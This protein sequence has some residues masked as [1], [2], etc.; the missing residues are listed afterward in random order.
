MNFS[1]NQ[2]TQFFLLD[3]AAPTGVSTDGGLKY[4]VTHADGSVEVT[5]V[6]KNVSYAKVLSAS[7]AAIKL[8]AGRIVL[9]SDVADGAPVTGQTYSICIN[10]AG[11]IGGEDSYHKFASV[12]A[13]SAMHDDA[14]KFYKAL[15][16]DLLRQAKVE[17][18]P[19]YRIFVA[20]AADTVGDEITDATI[21]TVTFTQYGLFIAEPV[22]HWELGCF[23]LNTMTMSISQSPIWVAGDEVVNWLDSEAKVFATTVDTLNNSPRIADLEYFCY[24]EKGNSNS[25]MGWPYNIPAKLR[26]NGAVSTTVADG[27]STL[28]IQY[29]YVGDNANNQKS[30]KTIVFAIKGT[31]V[32]ALETIKTAVDALSSSYTVA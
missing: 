11:R 21:D 28:T 17:Y 32:T 2:V 13:T 6:I 7:D 26:V 19:L 16:Q 30:E 27:Y 12:K 31:T 9:S 14:T 10:Y 1:T 15:A 20:S 3:G 29:A 8:K 18:Q 5:D 24:G 25:K 4:T 22:P 23:P